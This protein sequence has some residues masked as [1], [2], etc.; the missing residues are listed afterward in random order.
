MTTSGA[1]YCGVPTIDTSMVPASTAARHQVNN[2]IYDLSDVWLTHLGQPE[3][4]DFYR[5][6]LCR[7]FLCD[8]DVLLNVSSAAELCLIPLTSGFRSRCVT[9]LACWKRWSALQSALGRTVYAIAEQI[10]SVNRA[11][12]SS[13]I[14]QH[15]QRCLHGSLDSRLTKPSP[16][17]TFGVHDVIQQ[18]SAINVLEH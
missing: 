5:S 1:R 14:K 7:C 12:T 17:G 15:R 18:I 16:G 4:S 10:C 2:L 9:P 8:Q 11:V 3:I 6:W 13:A